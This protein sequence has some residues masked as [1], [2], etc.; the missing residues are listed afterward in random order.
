MSVYLERA[1]EKLITKIYMATK[2]RIIYGRAEIRNYFFSSVEFD[3]SR[4]SAA[5]EWD[6]ELITG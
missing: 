3:I 5:K 6:I 2:E 1:L 4:M